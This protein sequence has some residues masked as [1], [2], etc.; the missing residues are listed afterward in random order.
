[1]TERI[2]AYEQLLEEISPSQD[3]SVQTRVSKALEKVSDYKHWKTCR[4]ADFYCRNQ[5]RTM[6]THNR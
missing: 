4:P 1:M 3:V 6:K 2:K 5:L